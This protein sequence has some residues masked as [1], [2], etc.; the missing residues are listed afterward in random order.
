[1]TITRPPGPK[2][3]GRRATKPLTAKQLAEQ[4]KA[5]DDGG[6]HE[7]KRE[8]ARNFGFFPTPPALVQ[9]VIEAAGL[10]RRPGDPR[11][12]LLEPSAGTGN[13]AKAAVEAA[14]IV[15]CIEIQAEH[16][17]TLRAS[18][19]YR[20]VTKA[21]FLDVPPAPTY[22]RVLMNPPFDR[23][24]DIDHVMHALRFL[25]PGGVLVAI[26]SAHTEFAESRKAR[27]FRDHIAK[28]GGSFMDLPRNSFSAS[29]TNV[30]TILLTVRTVVAREATGIPAGV[31]A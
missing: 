18:G 13:I 22:D 15:D 17:L 30:N 29:G 6:L 14:A 11:I 7:P 12:H 21:D 8:V 19:R 10:Y 25:K 9:R 16:A 4:R 2:T 3:A 28:L 20:R 31:A 23:E 24:R 5:E 26:M 27:A 1:M